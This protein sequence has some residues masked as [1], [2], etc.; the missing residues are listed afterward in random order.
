[1]KK[2]L[3]WLVAIPLIAIGWFTYADNEFIVHDTVD[4]TITVY[5][6]W[7]D[8]K[9]Y[10]ITI[11]DKDLWAENVGDNGK[12]FQWWNN[13]WNDSDGSNVSTLNELL[14]DDINKWVNKG[15]SGN[16]D[17]F[18]IFDNWNNNT[19]DYRIGVY[20]TNATDNS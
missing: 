4:W 8:W 5:W 14:D 15:Y 18:I 12:Y 3:L 1:M 16:N 2:K 17:K 11:Q 19:Y 9:I 10:W 7:A 13:H 6:T 20:S